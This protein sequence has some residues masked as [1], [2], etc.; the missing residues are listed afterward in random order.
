MLKADILHDEIMD[1]CAKVENVELN[2]RDDVEAFVRAYTKLTYDHCMFGMMHDYYIY[3]VEVLRENALRLRGVEQVIADRQA[4]LA[5]YPNLKT[6]VQ[7]VI[8]APDNKGGWRVFRRMYLTG[9]NTGPSRKGPATGEELGENSLALSMFYLSLIDG[10]WR[11]TYEMDM[12]T[13]R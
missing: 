3:D 11:I 4:L 9:T 10:Q 1:L 2:N 6:D 8:V 12:R 13:T 7:K 5:A